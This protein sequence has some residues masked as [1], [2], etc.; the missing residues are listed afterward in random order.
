MFDVA[1]ESSSLARELSFDP[2]WKAA[3]GAL[4]R[5]A[6]P[7]DTILAPVEF[8]HFFDRFYPIHIQLTM[9]SEEPPV[10]SSNVPFR[11]IRALSLLYFSRTPHNFQ[12]DGKPRVLGF[13]YRYARAIQP[14]CDE[15]D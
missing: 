15:S 6:D 14:D 8:M 5:L 11:L 2:Y 4:E 13:Y 12:L 3:L 1:S 10:N 9:I 7:A